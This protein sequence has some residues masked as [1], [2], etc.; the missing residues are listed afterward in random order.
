VHSSAKKDDPR[1]YLPEA[2]SDDTEMRGLM[3]MP[4][5]RR[6][7]PTN[8]DRVVNFWTNV[9]NNY[10]QHENK[11]LITLDELKENLRRG[12][13]LPSPLSIAIEEM[14]KSGQMQTKND[15]D[16]RNQGW[17]QWTSSYLSS[18]ISNPEVDQ[19]EIQLI[20]QPTLRALATKLLKFYRDDFEMVDA[21]DIVEYEELRT[22]ATSE[23]IIHPECFDLVINEL[24]RLGEV[25]IGNPSGVEKVLKF[26]DQSSKGPAKFTESDASLHDLK[27]AMGKI[28]AD[29][30]RAEERESRFKEQAVAAMKKGDKKAALEF[31]RKKKQT[32]DQIAAKDGQYRHMVNMLETLAQTKQSKETVEAYKAGAK[33]FKETLAR[34]G[35]TLEDVDTT[36]DSVHEALQEFND[37]STSIREGFQ[38]MPGAIDESVNEAELEDELN[39]ILAEEGMAPPASELDSEKNLVKVGKRILDMSDLPDVP[40]RSPGKS[41][42]RPTTDK[43]LEERWKRLRTAAQ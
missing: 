20:H 13:Q 11:C 30:R 22:R 3:S 36:M 43:E 1:P 6:I 27:K 14:K 31:L 19:G 39:A 17:L 10:C 5:A 29:I 26:K 18:W 24:V 41:S 7:N 35:L 23:S 9:I 25:S 40:N 34:Q 33:A 28:E 8:Y 15:Y 4:K 12:A 38:N 21:P 2:W 42:P 32:T 37:V 16:K